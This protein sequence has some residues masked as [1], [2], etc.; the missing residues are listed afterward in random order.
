MSTPLA[1]NVSVFSTIP[2]SKDI[3]SREYL[4]SVAD[5]AR[6][7]EAAGCVGTLVYTDNGLVDPWLVAQVILQSTD[8]LLPL[9]AVQPLY[10]HPYTVAKMVASLAFLHRRRIYLNMLAGGF[11]NDLLALGDTT[12]HDERYART[13]EYTLII[14][15]LLSSPD[16]VSFAGSYYTVQGLKMSPPLPSDL[17]PGFTMSGSSAAGLA[18]A[19]AVGAVAIQ[20]PKPPGEE[21]VRSRTETGVRIGIVARETD[22]E[23]WRV[24]YERF[25]EDRKGQIMHKLAMKVSDSQ[26]HEQ[27]SVLAETKASERQAYWLGPFQNYQ[28]F[29]PYLV[30]SY[31][32]V[33]QELT[34]YVAAGR[35]TFVLDIPPSEAELKHIGVVFD[36]LQG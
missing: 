33:A 3:G 19:E 8:R 18:A 26:W 12:P 9:V 28:T 21:V 2:Q 1:G 36:G 20:Y 30:G 32:R 27:L 15:K 4:R 34:R 31:E 17:L 23:A 22:E 25:P 5:V 14:Q 35:S 16:P 13:L 6:W 29:C 10:M 11:K 24:A 7:S